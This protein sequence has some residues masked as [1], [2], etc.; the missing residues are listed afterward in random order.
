MMR[1]VIVPVL[2][3]IFATR[4]CIHW[5]AELADSGGRE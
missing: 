2:V 4:L 5:F 3:L 1:L